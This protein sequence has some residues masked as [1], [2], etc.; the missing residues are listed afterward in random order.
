MQRRLSFL[1][2]AAEDAVHEL[3]RGE[4]SYEDGERL[5]LELRTV[6]AEVRTLRTK[7]MLGEVV[8]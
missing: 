8:A 2:A 4:L 1:V 5:T 3:W 7:L 6:Q